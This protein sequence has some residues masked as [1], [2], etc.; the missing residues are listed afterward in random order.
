MKMGDVDHPPGSPDRRNARRQ[1]VRRR[2]L[3]DEVRHTKPSAHPSGDLDVET[4]AN[5][6]GQRRRQVTRRSS[7]GDGARVEATAEVHPQPRRADATRLDRLGEQAGRLIGRL[8]ERRRVFDPRDVVPPPVPFGRDRAVGEIEGD[9]A[10]GRHQLHTREPRPLSKHMTDLNELPHSLFVDPRH[11]R[12]H[13][14]Q[15]AQSGR[16][17][18]SA[19]DHRPEEEAVPETISHEVDTSRAA[20]MHHGHIAAVEGGKR[21]GPPVSPEKSSEHT[22]SSRPGSRF[23]AATGRFS[24]IDLAIEPDSHAVLL[25]KRRRSLSGAVHRYRREAPL[26]VRRIPRPGMVAFELDHPGEGPLR[27]RPPRIVSG[28][29]P[30]TC[31]STASLPVP[32][33]IAQYERT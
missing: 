19:A 18:Q 27:A 10:P 29:A 15:T 6:E 32:R 14:E 30:E 33:T 21:R 3:V 26:R 7:G 12:R 16:P 23:E 5:A 22:D 25:G 4:V 2:Q 17:G 31:H 13:R 20:V 1:P 28:E 11:E 24:R 9:D 8:D